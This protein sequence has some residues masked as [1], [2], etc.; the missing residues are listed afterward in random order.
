MPPQSWTDPML[1]PVMCAFFGLLIYFLG[2]KKERD[3]GKAVWKWAGVVLAVLGGMIGWPWFAIYTG[4]GADG[5]LY[6]SSLMGNKMLVGHYAALVV[7][8]LAVIV[9]VGFHFIHVKQLNDMQFQD[10]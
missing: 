9:C 10:E 2:I 1:M 6:R 7:P 8:L 5:E 4:K 3:G